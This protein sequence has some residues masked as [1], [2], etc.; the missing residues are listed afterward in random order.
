MAYWFTSVPWQMFLI[1]TPQLRRRND[2]GIL[3]DP[4]SF[5]NPESLYPSASFRAQRLSRTLA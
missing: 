1:I 2:F 4:P 3:P 5:A